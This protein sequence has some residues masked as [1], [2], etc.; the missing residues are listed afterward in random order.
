MSAYTHS[1]LHF[2]CF[3]FK[4]TVHYTLLKSVLVD[5]LNKLDNIF[6]VI[7]WH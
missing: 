6:H 5:L 7:F 1:A 3:Q 4:I 2:Q